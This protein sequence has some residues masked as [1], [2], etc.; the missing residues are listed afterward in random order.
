MRVTFTREAIEDLVGIGEHIYP[1][2][3][4]RADSFVTELETRCLQLAEMHLAFLKS[5]P[6]SGDI[7]RGPHGKYLIFYEVSDAEIS[8]LRVLHGAQDY[9]K[10]L[11]P[12]A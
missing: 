2:N 1:S 11:F 9:T 7:R 12:E 6:D 8:I 5:H 10:I 4:T 3:P